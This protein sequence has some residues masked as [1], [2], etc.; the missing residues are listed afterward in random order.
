[1]GKGRIGGAWC[2]LRRSS[3]AGIARC[4]RGLTGLAAFLQSRQSPVVPLSC[5]TRPA[6]FTPPAAR[7]RGIRRSRSGQIPP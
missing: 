3:A 1:L 5:S 2:S 7:W 6:S 4:S